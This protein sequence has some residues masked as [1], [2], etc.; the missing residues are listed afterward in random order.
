MKKTE[1]VTMYKVMMPFW[2]GFG[3]QDL[4]LARF[5]TKIEAERYID[6]YLNPFLRPYLYISIIKVQ[7]QET[8]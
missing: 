1:K 7:I 8:D 6:N 2:F 3:M 5:F 4:E